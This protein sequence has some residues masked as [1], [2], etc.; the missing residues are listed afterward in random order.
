MID[1]LTLLTWIA[2]LAVLYSAWRLACWIEDR[3][4]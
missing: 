4:A 2:G 1:G 3:N